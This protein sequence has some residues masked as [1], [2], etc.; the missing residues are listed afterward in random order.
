[1][2]G[3]EARDVIP[4]AWAAIRFAEDDFDWGAKIGRRTFDP[5]PRNALFGPTS[6][7]AY[8]RFATGRC[9]C[10]GL[11]PLGW[12]RFVGRDAA[13]F[14]DRITPLETVWRDR[15]EALRAAVLEADDPAQ[16]FDAFFTDL[17][18]RTPP[19]DEAV[20]RVAALL[21]DP[22]V[23]TIKEMTERTGIDARHIARLSTR[24]FGF[25]PKLL[26]RR[27][28]FM[29]ALIAS[30]QVG[31]GGWKALVVA[32]GYHDQPHFIRD[33]QLFLGMPIS[34][35]MLKPKPL[36]ELSLRLRAQVVGTPAQALHPVEG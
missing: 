13:P 30:M 35:F 25:T 20:A 19:E 7:A 5:G 12:A 26:L 28:R 16:A 6:H 21:L 32:A 1:M 3:E 11:T 36:F 8:T 34:S 27:A 18:I 15:T 33:C 2:P 14:A 9:V 31:R 17:L 23:L 22:E 10:V 24:Y 4:P 29:R